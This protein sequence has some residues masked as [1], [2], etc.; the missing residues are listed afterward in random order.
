MHLD[1]NIKICL[2]TAQCIDD[3]LHILYAC[4]NNVSLPK[5]MVIDS[6]CQ[7]RVLAGLFIIS[8]ALSD[9]RLSMLCREGFLLRLFL[10]FP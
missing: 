6:N 3:G 5:N 2:D 1:L 4:D 10:I 7:W 8:P 9:L